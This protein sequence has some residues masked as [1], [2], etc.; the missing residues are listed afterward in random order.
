MYAESQASSHLPLRVLDQCEVEL[1]QLVPALTSESE[2]DC[3][4]VER[5]VKGVVIVTAG[6]TW[7]AHTEE[8]LDECVVDGLPFQCD[9]ERAEEFEA[10]VLDPFAVVLSEFFVK[11][12]ELRTNS[13]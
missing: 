11:F 6:V 8:M 5:A 3:W 7:V 4:K 9:D 10:G 2:D 1:F 12:Y 13:C